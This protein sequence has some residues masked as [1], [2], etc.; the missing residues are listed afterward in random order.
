MPPAERLQKALAA[1]G[2]GSRRKCEEM[3]EAGRIS[4]NGEVAVLGDRIDA[5]T[6]KV[7]VD[8]IPIDF[9]IEK[10]YFLLNKP[11]GFI[12]TVKDTHGRLTVMHLMKEKER[13]FPVGRLDKDTRGL[14]LITND[15]YLAQKMMHPSQGVEKTYLVQAEGSLTQE[16]LQKLRKGIRLDEGK[17]Q[18][19]RV[20]VLRHVDNRALLEM[21]IHEGKK[22]QVRRMMAAIG[23][24]VLDLI[25]TRV[26]PL[27]LHGVEEGAYRPLTPQEI[28]KLLA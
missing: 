4:L 1:A 16:G 25:R 7:E 11:A 8:G 23:L 5:E 13:L 24:E 18:P 9:A 15:G 20:R 3:I 19:A 6:D 12:T 28:K 22:R 17:T 27:T 26:G 2:L 21:T 14:L 10:K